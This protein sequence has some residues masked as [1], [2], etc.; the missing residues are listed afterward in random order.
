MRSLNDQGGY[1]PNPFLEF[2]KKL[3]AKSPACNMP[4]ELSSIL[5]LR[6]NWG[7]DVTGN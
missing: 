6:R 3:S 4:G 5:G 7:R 2:T 1:F